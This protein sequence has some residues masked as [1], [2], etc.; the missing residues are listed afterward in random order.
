[1]GPV[2]VPEYKFVLA[3]DPGGTTGLAFRMPDGSYHTAIALT[4]EQVWDF[5]D[6]R[7]D[8]VIY[9]NFA[10][11]TISKYGIHTLK[12]IG[13]I[14]AMCWKHRIPIIQRQPQSRY[15]MLLE[16]KAYLKE[17]KGDSF[18]VHEV[19]ALAHLMTW[20]EDK[21]AGYL[22]GTEKD[23]Q[24]GLPSKNNDNKPKV[25]RKKV[26]FNNLGKYA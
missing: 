15:G 10:A 23:K 8:L 2:P 4:P 17:N 9:E 12:V 24:F 3:I 19:D 11:V 25:N 18:V 1:M 16:A 7:V 5:I 21:Q 13:G 14:R 6:D 22:V 26:N 20:D